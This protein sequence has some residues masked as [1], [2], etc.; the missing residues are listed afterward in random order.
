MKFNKTTLSVVTISVLILAGCGGGSS[1]D[2]PKP[3]AQ[4]GYMVGGLVEGVP[5]KCGTQEG[6]TGRLG[7]YSYMAGDACEFSLGKNKFSVSADKVQKGYL[8]V[9]DLAAT[10]EQAW[11][12][13]AIMQSISYGRPKLTPSA[14]DI[15]LI[16]D[17]NLEK[18]IPKVDLS[19]GDAAVTAALVP[20][21]NTVT[22]VTVADA[23]ARLG[24]S[25]SENNQPLLSLQ[26]LVLA[27]QAELDRLQISAVSGT[28]YQSIGLTETNQTNVVNLVL[29]DGSGNPMVVN[30]SGWSVNPNAYIWVTPGQDPLGSWPVIGQNQADM[31]G[32]NVMGISLNVGRQT[33]D[34]V[35]T[36]FFNYAKQG[37]FSPTSIF[38]AG[39]QPDAKEN[40]AFPPSLNFG[41]LA[42]LIGQTSSAQG[43]TFSCNNMMFAQGS[44]QGSFT[45]FLNATL[46]LVELGLDTAKMV[47]LDGQDIAADTQFAGA[48]ASFGT[49]ISKLFTQ[50]WWVFAVSGLTQNARMSVN[51]NPAVVMNCMSGNTPI[52]VVVTSTVDDHTFNVQVT[53]P[54]Q[55]LYNV[56]LPN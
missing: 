45:G 36:S 48:A 14:R 53:Y 40:V 54:Q 16:V 42:N 6:R 52:S 5:Y 39:A 55:T 47:A 21:A 4:T 24:T 10:K 9:Y 35:G 27:G 15:F 28:P 51:G 31:T 23:R 2:A 7:Q 34:S 50:N 30:P 12:L 13:M 25:V 37:S 3:V 46:D 49:A 20:F 22:P 26:Q 8:S 17:V 41:F 33:S 29:Y 32:S 43:S 44:T 11:T 38:A 1:N 18:R 56:D 19:F